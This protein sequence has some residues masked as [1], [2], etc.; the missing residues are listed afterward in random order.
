MCVADEFNKSEFGQIMLFHSL[1]SKVRKQSMEPETFAF[2]KLSNSFDLYDFTMFL[3]FED[4]PYKPSVARGHFE[5]FV[6]FEQL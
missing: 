5:G 3:P 2:D 4:L 1:L 6:N